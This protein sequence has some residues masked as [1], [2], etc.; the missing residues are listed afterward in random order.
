MPLPDLTDAELMESR[1]LLL[2]FTRLQLPDYPDLAED[3]VQETLL[4]AYSAGDSFQGRALVN[5]WLF[6]ILK[7]KIIDAL[8]QI[9]RQRKVFTALDDEL[10]DETF[11]SHFF[12]NG[13]WTPEG[14]PQH[15]N[16][17]EKSLNNN[18]FQKILQSCLYNLPENTA[19]VFT[20]KEI[21]GFSSNEIQQMCGISTANYHTI[22]HRARESL[23][24]CLQI[25]W[26][27]QENPK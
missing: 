20:L 19:R 11:E 1:K 13:H 21:L 27:N 26:F 17:P 25:K 4:S 24:Q 9:G 2:H 22:M 14:Q 16:N 3:L 12:P 6:A 7:N 10:L 5:S 18:E 23:R 8:R 15:W